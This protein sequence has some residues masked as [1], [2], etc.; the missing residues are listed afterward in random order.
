MIKEQNRTLSQ[1]NE[2][3]TSLNNAS[4]KIPNTI[5]LTPNIEFRNK[6]EEIGNL[7]RLVLERKH[8]GTRPGVQLDGN[9]IELW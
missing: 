8:K 6:Y 5:L 3:K 7:I 9:K 2:L 4:R 1:S